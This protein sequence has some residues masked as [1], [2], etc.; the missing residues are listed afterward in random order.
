MDGGEGVLGTMWKRVRLTGNLSGAGEPRR[1]WQV[2]VQGWYRRSAPRW[3]EHE[4]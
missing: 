4:N 1:A 3:G 2:R